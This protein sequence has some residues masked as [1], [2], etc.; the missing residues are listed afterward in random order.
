MQ[1]WSRV[2]ERLLDGSF[3]LVRAMATWALQR[4]AAPERWA[5]AKGRRLRK[6]ADPDVRAELDQLSADT[7]AA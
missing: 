6:E 3:P 4:L 2:V 1:A 7:S 5:E